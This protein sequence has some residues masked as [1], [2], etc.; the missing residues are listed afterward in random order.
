MGTEWEINIT[1]LRFERVS[2][3]KVRLEVSWEIFNLNFKNGTYPLQNDKVDTFIVIDSNE[4]RDSLVKDEVRALSKSLGDLSKLICS[5]I[6][7]Q[8]L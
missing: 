8:N 4:K 2:E 6:V 7:S 3:N 5:S 1:I